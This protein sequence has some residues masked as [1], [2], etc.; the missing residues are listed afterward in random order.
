MMTHFFGFRSAHRSMG[1]SLAGRATCALGLILLWPA[2]GFAQKPTPPIDVSI[3]AGDTGRVLGETMTVSLSVTPRKDIA[4]AR[5]HFETVSTAI[6]LLNPQD[7]EL[8]GLVQGKTYTAATQVR[9]TGEGKSELRG[10]AYAIDTNGGILFGRSQALDIIVSKTDVLV[11]NTSFED[12]LIKDARKKREAKSLTDTQYDARIDSIIGGKGLESHVPVGPPPSAPVAGKSSGAKGLVNVYGQILWTDSA[13]ATHPAR[14]VDVEIRDDNGAAPSDLLTTVSTDSYGSYYAYSL[15]NTDSEGPGGRDILI[16]A[17]TNN[18]RTRVMNVLTG[19]TYFMESSVTANVADDSY[20]TINLTANNTDTPQRAF[21]VEDALVTITDYANY[22]ASGYLAKIDVDFPTADETSNFFNG[23]LH[24]LGDDWPDWDVIHHEFGHYFM[25]TEGIENNPGGDHAL[26]ENL[27]ERVGKDDGIRLAWGEGFP[28]YFGASGQAVTSAIYLGVPNVGD[29]SYTDTI[30]STNNYNL[31]SFA[32]APSVGED[33]EVSVQR[34]LWDLYDTADDMRDTVSFGYSAVFDYAHSAGAKTLS[35]YW[36]SLTAAKALNMKTKV[37]CGCIFGDNK[38]AP[39]PTAPDDNA[40]V[41]PSDTPVT[42]TWDANG[43]GPSHRN[44]KSDW[45]SIFG[46]DTVARWVVVGRNDDAPATGAYISCSRRI[47]KADIAFVID[48]T[49]SMTEEIGGVK[50]ALTDL[51]SLF[52]ALDAHVTIHLM[53]FKDNVTSRIMTNDLPAVQ[54]VV[55]TLFADGGGDCPESSVE[56][57]LEA[58]TTLKDGGVAFL[59][60]DADPHAGLDIPAAIAALRAKG[61]RVNILLS[62][63]CSES[64]KS[65]TQNGT[66]LEPSVNPGWPAAL[67]GQVA[68][69]F[70]TGAISAFS[71]LAADTGG[72]F[73]FIPGVNGGDPSGPTQYR[74]TAL[75]VMKASALPSIP[76]VLPSNGPRGTVLGL[77]ITGSNTNFSGTSV[78]TVS[79]TGI[80]VNSGA[81]TSPISYNAVITIAPDADLGFR[82]VTVTTSLAKSTSEVATGTGA[83]EV[84]DTLVGPAIVG[85]S[86]GQASVGSTLDVDIYGANT[87]FASES[88]ADLSHQGFSEPGGITINSFTALN[89]THGRAN[90]SVAAVAQIGYR[91]VTVTTGAETAAETVPG[92]F[93]VTLAPS[94]GIPRLVSLDPAVGTPATSAIVDVVGENTHFAN[95]VSVGSLSG[96]GITVQATTV[97]DATHAQLSLGIDAGAALGFRDVFITTGA[98]VASI[99][100]AF[101]IGAQPPTA[102]AGPDQIV[103][104]TGATADVTL[105]GTGSIAYGATIASYAW[106]GSPDPDDVA[107]PA[108]ALPLG[109]YTFTLVVTDSETK[110]SGADP[111]NVVVKRPTDIDAD[112]LINAVDVQLVINAALSIAIAFDADVNHDTNVNAVDVQMVINGALGLKK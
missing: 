96:T 40:S 26:D 71:A 62:G 32:G 111:V 45:A 17:F 49:G 53:T 76:S 92:P 19:K 46:T 57:L 81:A 110:S 70:P 47:G 14:Y 72:I 33:N 58:G 109:T 65:V 25:T 56:A 74:N 6:T 99:L 52:A 27:G 39:E 8:T 51:I 68:K 82:D 37:A 86:P 75:N 77:T 67:G 50:T 84:R 21:C 28:T 15:D 90:I 20:V 42:F 5:I 64:F 73:S 95:G 12:L 103:N 1:L 83:F 69:D 2:V 35:A 89:P 107:S 16:R 108:L 31:E 18:T 112:Q 63:S 7:G 22:L 59:A 48:D 78:L 101:E 60:T 54:A 4:R 29:T 80:T 9:L 11:G 36:N 85:V 30:D 44:K 3:A 43:G 97:S 23:I 55:N 100:N 94:S 24:I 102:N 41:G 104:T 61:I 105:D 98:E 88:V 91:D 13:G 10:W 34:I 93:L 38:V 87:N 79:G 106:T 66:V